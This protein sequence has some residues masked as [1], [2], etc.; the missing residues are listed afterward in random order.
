VEEGRH[1]RTRGARGRV[2]GSPASGA[3]P[4]RTTISPSAAAPGSRPGALSGAVVNGAGGSEAARAGAPTSRRL[5]S[6]TKRWGWKHVAFGGKWGKAENLVDRGS[7]RQGAESMM[8]LYRDHS[9]KG[10]TPSGMWIRLKPSCERNPDGQGSEYLN[11]TKKHPSTHLTPPPG[12]SSLST[13][14]APCGHAP[15][16]AGHGRR[17]PGPA[18]GG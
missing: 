11:P 10:G 5:G 17:P 1:W 15:A 12:P 16:R 9:L 18:A 2:V 3:T 14:L 8:Y 13:P 4:S 6:N 7:A